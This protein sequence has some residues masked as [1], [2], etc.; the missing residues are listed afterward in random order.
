MSF[1]IETKIGTLNIATQEREIAH[2]INPQFTVRQWG[3]GIKA[4]WQSATTIEWFDSEE[5]RNAAEGH[6]VESFRRQAV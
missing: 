2:H 1:T 5:A 3:L 4:P 6:A